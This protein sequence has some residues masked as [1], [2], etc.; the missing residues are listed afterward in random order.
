VTDKQPLK[1]SA[2]QKSFVSCPFTQYDGVMHNEC[3][4]SC[5]TEILFW[6]PESVSVCLSVWMLQSYDYIL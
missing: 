5:L 2:S 1:N 4:Y 3:S 6:L